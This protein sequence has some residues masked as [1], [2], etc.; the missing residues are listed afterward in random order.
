MSMEEGTVRVW[1]RAAVLGVFSIVLTAQVFA[2]DAAGPAKVEPELAP[3]PA[4]L[5]KI[6][7]LPDNT[8]LKLPPFKVTGE[9]KWLSQRADERRRGPFGRDY[10][11]HA[12]W[13][14]E[15]K[16]AIYLGGGHNVRPINDVWEYDLAANTWVCLRGA[17]PRCGRTAEWVRKNAM[18]KDG[19]L[20]TKTGAPVRLLH[21][22]DQF[23]YDPVRRLALLVHST[24]RNFP[25]VPG[26]HR[27]TLAQGLGLTPDQLEKRLVKDGIYI[28]G[29]DAAKRTWTSIEFMVNWKGPGNTIGG[30]QEGGV[31]E[32]M[33]DKNTLWFCGYSGP[34]VRDAATGKW[35]I[36]K[37]RRRVYAPVAVYDSN[38]RQ[39]VIVINDRTIV[40][41][42]DGTKWKVLT[43][44]P[45]KGR[46]SSAGLVYDPVAKRAV[47]YT[48]STTPHLWLFDVASGKWIDPKPK[49]DIPAGGRMIVYYDE[50]RN[51]TV[52]YNSRSIWVYRCKRAKK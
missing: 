50:A 13:A 39:M 42:P 48:N 9:L 43:G 33:P 27:G 8:W 19:V 32:Y 6:E 14:P 52:Y 37:V 23:A 35:N 7:A 41:S 1:A 22:W 4:L 15:R 12:V 3:D 24:P 21:T 31:L 17:D 46:D 11:N 20:M 30:R 36:G 16:R 10:S 34:L 45:A 44:Q 40:G 26:I 51:V 18:L 38:T 47:L 29:F 5:A 49:G 28:W 25:A 2:A